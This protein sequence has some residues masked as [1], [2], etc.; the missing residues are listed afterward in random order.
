MF[1]HGQKSR[2]RQ[3]VRCPLAIENLESRLVL[4]T[5]S[6]S[7]NPFGVLVIKGSAGNDDAQ[8]TASGGKVPGDFRT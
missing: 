4:D 2:S 8:V 1:P 7:L 3:P 5:G 6:V